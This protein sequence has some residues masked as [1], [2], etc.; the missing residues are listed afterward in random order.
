MTSLRC[1]SP[2]TFKRTQ[3]THLAR[4]QS[5]YD[6]TRGSQHTILKATAY[7]VTFNLPDGSSPSI[8]CEENQ[9]IMEAAEAANIDLPC[10]CRAGTCF[11]CAARVLEGKV[12]NSD[13]LLLSEDAMAEGF[14]LLCTSFPRS[15]CLIQTHQ[16][17]IS[18][19]CSCLS[20]LNRYILPPYD[21]IM[22]TPSTRH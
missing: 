21:Q 22:S 14:A 7:N 6:S 4:R 15:D 16:V 9:C 20:D 3:V 11:T 2:L 1:A 8:Q 10:L 13:Q 18:Y 17:R 12:E 5:H 19:F